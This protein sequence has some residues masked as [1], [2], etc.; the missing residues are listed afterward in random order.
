DYIHHGQL[1]ERYPCVLRYA[2]TATAYAAT[3]REILDKLHLQGARRFVASFDRPN[4]RYRVVEKTEAKAQFLEFYRAKH[5]G[6]AGIVYCLSRKSV[7]ATAQWLQRHGIDA[8]AYHAGL[9]TQTRR[10]RQGQFLRRD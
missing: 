4:I 5:E 2:L 7:D 10:E 9:D 1:A 6:Q 8:L 3:R